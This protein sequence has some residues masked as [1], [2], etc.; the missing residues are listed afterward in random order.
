M[1]N[2]Y[3]ANQ[4]PWL[5]TDQLECFDFLCEIHSGGNHMF[6]KLYPCGVTGIYINSTN[7]GNRAATFDFDALTKAVILA[8]D[9]MIRF[10]VEPS[11]PGMLKLFAHK[12]HAREGRMH[13][14][15][16]TIEQAIFSVRAEFGG[17]L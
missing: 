16:P 11:G 13:E 6:G 5:N 1:R 17:S 3:Y 2:E 15:H 8:H 10:A 7:F 9:R 12:R 14:R 4:Y